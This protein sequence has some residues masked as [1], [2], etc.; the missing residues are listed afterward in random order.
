[1]FCNYGFRSFSEG[2]AEADYAWAIRE[3]SMNVPVI[4]LFAVYFLQTHL[5]THFTT[6]FFL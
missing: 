2:N 5:L 3:H 6:A 4:F 1:M